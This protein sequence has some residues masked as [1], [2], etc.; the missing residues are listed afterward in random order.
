LTAER[1]RHTVSKACATIPEG[2]PTS[3]SI[4]VALYPD[5]GTQE[6]E[7]LHAADLALYRA[8]QSGRDRVMLSENLRAAHPSLSHSS[9]SA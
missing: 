3:V 9:L 4:G 2:K 7:L 1:L 5:D 8:K 6:P